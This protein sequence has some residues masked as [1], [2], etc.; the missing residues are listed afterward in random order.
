MLVAL[1]KGDYDRFVESG[2]LVVISIVAIISP[3]RC[4]FS[5]NIRSQIFPDEMSRFGTT[6][7]WMMATAKLKA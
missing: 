6:R 7:G 2:V 3:S 4:H 5:Q 1:G